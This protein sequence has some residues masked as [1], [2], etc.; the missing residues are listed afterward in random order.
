MSF[1]TSN[2]VF[3]PGGNP[4]S[5]LFVDPASPNPGAVTTDSFFRFDPTNDRLII[6]GNIGAGID[7][8]TGN[9]RVSLTGN[10]GIGIGTQAG[11]SYF[12]IGTGPGAV[13]DIRGVFSNL[14]I[15]GTSS[16]SLIDVS[17]EWNTTGT[18]TGI[19]LNV[20]DTASNAASLLMDLQVGG[21]S[22]FAVRKSSIVT[23]TTFRVPENSGTIEMGGSGGSGT[24]FQ[25]SSGAQIRVYH[26]GGSTISL[27]LSSFVADSNSSFSFTSGDIG[28]ASDLFIRRDAANTLAQRNG[29][30]AQTLRVYNTFTDASNYERGIFSWVSNVLFIGNEGAGTG[31]TR[32]T[33]V[34]GSIFNV[35]IS[36]VDRWVFDASSLRPFVGNSYDIGGTADT[37]KNL[38]Q[39][40]YHQMVEMTAPAAPAA[41]SVRI[42]AEDNGSGKTRLMALFATGAAQQIAIEP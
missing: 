3:I 15:G 12:N 31:T 38:F 30:N 34:T 21:V 18:P 27:N 32:G 24:R 26:N 14:G 37:V 19:R 33:T 6:W 35:R 9:M 7:I 8:G 28:A 40:G 29:V 10:A 11:T 23:A 25:T 4:G 20:T 16:N 13:A 39:A 36:G 22:Q 1:Y 42:Y 41:N 2:N 17:G 5:I